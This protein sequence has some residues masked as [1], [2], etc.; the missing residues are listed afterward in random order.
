V[1]IKTEAHPVR[2]ASRMASAARVRERYLLDLVGGADEREL[3]VARAN[4]SHDSIPGLPGLVVV[5]GRRHGVTRSEGHPRGVEGDLDLARAAL[6]HNDRG[7]PISVGLHDDQREPVVAREHRPH[8]ELLVR[9]GDR[10]PPPVL[11]LV[12]LLEPVDVTEDSIEIQDDDIHVDVGL[13]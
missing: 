12:E 2:A 7:V 13:G 3:F 9:V 6:R 1:F 8:G 5:E 11:G 10:R 4:P